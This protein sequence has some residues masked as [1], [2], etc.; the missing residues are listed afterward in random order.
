MLIC[1]R[2]E[3]KTNKHIIQTNRQTKREKT[4]FIFFFHATSSNCKFVQ[5]EKLKENKGESIGCI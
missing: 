1:K 4:I 2:N 5:I 3:K